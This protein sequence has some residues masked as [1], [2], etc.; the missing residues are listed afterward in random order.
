MG[1][2][3]LILKQRRPEYAA[4][5]GGAPAPMGIAAVCFALETK[6]K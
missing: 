2:K 1:C 6:P 4:S 3:N 5:S